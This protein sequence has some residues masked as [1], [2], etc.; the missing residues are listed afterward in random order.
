MWPNIILIINRKAK[1]KIWMKNLFNSIRLI[2]GINNIGVFLGV[3][4]IKKIFILLFILNI[5]K[6][7]IN[8][9]EKFKVK[10]ILVEI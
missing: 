9:K 7:L 6:L 8:Q 5:K 10:M 4:F 3:R 2:K 1:V